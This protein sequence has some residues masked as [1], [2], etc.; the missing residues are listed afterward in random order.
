[1]DTWLDTVRSGQSSM[2]PLSRSEKFSAHDKE[3][4]RPS[5]RGTITLF[6]KFSDLT[7]RV[8]SGTWVYHVAN[9]TRVRVLVLK[10]FFFWLRR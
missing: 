9:I 6:S 1:M 3:R 4:T 8:G 10:C 2:W 5:D 7:N